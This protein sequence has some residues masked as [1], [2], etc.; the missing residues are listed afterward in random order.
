MAVNVYS[1]NVSANQI[2]RGDLV[3][4]VNERLA[5]DYKKVENLCS[6]AAYC[7]FMDQ[8]FP[9]SVNMK[10]VKFDAKND[11]QY[12]ENF[13]LLQA[14]F[15]KKAVDKVIPVER[16]CKGRF[17]DN[18]EFAQWFKKFYDANF[19]G[20]DGYDP[21]ARRKGAG[22][23]PSAKK[24]TTA[25]A[26]AAPSSSSRPK[27][28]RSPVASSGYG[29][30]SSPTRTSP[31]RSSGSSAKTKELEKRCTELQLVIDGLE[32]ERDFYFAKLRDIE[33]LC[34]QPEVETMSIVQEITRVLYATEEG[35]EVPTDDLAEDGHE[36]Y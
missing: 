19:N 34:Q 20:D 3:D 31:T 29:P 11:Y 26:R 17:Q 18:F 12:I 27:P 33:V 30:S 8:L 14:S 25:S 4:W 36:E 22:G 32:K 24:K 9:G 13:K 28:A 1:T 21:S 2:S 10:K 16:L 5:M 35:F 7:Q 15:R 6:G 23:P